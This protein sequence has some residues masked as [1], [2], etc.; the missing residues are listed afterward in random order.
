M[1]LRGS[2]LAKS[3]RSGDCLKSTGDDNRLSANIMQ[4]FH[5]VPLYVRLN[6]RKWAWVRSGRLSDSFLCAISR[7]LCN[8]HDYWNLPDAYII[9]VCTSLRCFLWCSLCSSCCNK[10][11]KATFLRQFASRR[12][13]DFILR[14][15]GS[16]NKIC[17]QPSYMSVDAKRGSSV[18]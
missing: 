15:T 5:R 4:L 7:T 9:S 12:G 1:P 3:L 16:I 2:R 8:C 10:P 17:R 18:G 11:Y 13:R 14:N 6:G